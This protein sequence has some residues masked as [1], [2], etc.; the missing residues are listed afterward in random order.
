MAA[1]AGPTMD[2]NIQ[3]V[4]SPHQFMQTAD[5]SNNNSMMNQYLGNMMNQQPEN[6]MEFQYQNN[7]LNLQSQ[8]NLMH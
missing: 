8:I 7:L 4:A 2:P 3:G 5:M 1:A 6:L